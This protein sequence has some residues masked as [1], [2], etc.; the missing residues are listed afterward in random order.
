MSIQGSVNQLLGFGAL[1][2]GG[3]EKGMES[4]NQ[5]T[6][7]TSQGLLRGAQERIN[8][9]QELFPEYG[10]QLDSYQKEVTNLA[11]NLERAGEGVSGSILGQR[12]YGKKLSQLGKLVGGVSSKVS[13]FS[14]DPNIREA[15][16]ER[17][18]QAIDSRQ[19]TKSSLEDRIQ[20]TKQMFDNIRKGIKDE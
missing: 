16:L 14:P 7:T 2:A 15:A 17:A 20:Q 8:E 19:G 11:T 1:A 10:E 3:I 13:G 18:Q 6:L 12:A 9:G 5:R 4:D